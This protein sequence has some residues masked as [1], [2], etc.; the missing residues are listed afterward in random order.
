M[1]TPAPLTKADTEL[2]LRPVLEKAPD[3]IAVAVSG[4]ADSFALLWLLSQ[5]KGAPK[6]LALTVDHGLRT[7]AVN[8]AA[9]VAGWCKDHNI[10]HRTLCWRGPKPETGIQAAA[11]IARYRLL[12]QACEET[13]H[14]WLLT[15]HNADDQ[16]ET[17]FAR[18]ARGS[19]P[20]GLASMRSFSQIAAR[21]GRPVTLVR[22]LLD[23]ARDRLRATASLIKLPFVDDPS[24]DDMTFERVKR[25]AFLAAIEAQDLL[26]KAALMRLAKQMRSAVELA[27]E[28]LHQDYRDAGGYFHGS[29]S[30]CFTRDTYKTLS[31]ARQSRLLSRT[32]EAVSGSQYPPER[33]G[34]EK[35]VAGI[36]AGQKILTLGG[37]VVSLSQRDLFVMREPHALLG[38]AD[39]KVERYEVPVTAGERVLWDNR[40]IVIVP[41]NTPEGAALAPIGL[42]QS[43]PKDAA[44]LASSL[45][46]LWYKTD[47][48]AVPGYAKKMLSPAAAPWNTR[49]STLDMRLL[50]E[51]RFNR[52]VI[53]F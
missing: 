41:E 20:A 33:E 1:L 47:L 9:T 49:A 51:E 24:N 25:R 14:T 26:E 38:R 52:R 36:C 35:I 13:G 46:G 2:I 17:V 5:I 31:R 42:A 53:R 19:G 23:I 43:G 44:L 6:I 4:G 48:V 30:I 29:S 22:P 39:G 50:I 3:E 10:R 34:V 12:A 45:P 16:A 28:A 7:E 15:A 8:D 32:I 11:R 40:L 21:A 18:L 37:V 27:E